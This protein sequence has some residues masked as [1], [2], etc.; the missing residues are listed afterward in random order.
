MIQTINGGNEKRIVHNQDKDQFH[1]VW[2]I[3]KKNKSQISI[4][5]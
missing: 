2:K 1:G 3:L 5:I 4:N